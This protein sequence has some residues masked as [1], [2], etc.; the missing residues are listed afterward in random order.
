MSSRLLWV[1]SNFDNVRECLKNNNL[2]FGTLD[3]WLL[4]KLTKGRIY[5][6]DVS[7]ASATGLFDI[8]NLSWGFLPLLLKIPYNILPK[9]VDN[10][11]S[12]GTTSCEI[13][14]QPLNIGCSVKHSYIY[15]YFF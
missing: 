10:D 12:F 6:T 2:M 9:I 11:Y 4:Y 7:S 8:F 5:V 1:L 3:T 13:F 15:I 14:G